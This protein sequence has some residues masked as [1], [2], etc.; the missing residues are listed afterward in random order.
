MSINPNYYLFLVETKN[1][2]TKLLT[3]ALALPMMQGIA[4]LY[5]DARI[6]T[7]GK[8]LYTFQ[9][10]LK[11]VPSWN[12]HI[13]E[14]ETMRIIQKTAEKKIM[15][16]DFLKA[17]IKSNIMILTNTPPEKKDNLKIKHDITIKKFI[18]NAYI[19]IARNIFQ[20]PFL[21]DHNCIDIDIKRNQRETI[22]IIKESI[23][24]TI[25]KLLPLN[26]ILQKYIGETFENQTD[27][28]QN[29]IS[30]SEYNNARLLLNKDPLNNNVTYQLVKNNDIFNQ[31]QNGKQQIV[32]PEQKDNQQIQ[33]K[34]TTPPEQ[35]NIQLPHSNII[36]K[37]MQTKTENAIKETEAAKTINQVELNHKNVLPTP[38]DQSE[39]KQQIENK[40]DD[41]IVSSVAYY[42]RSNNVIEEYGNVKDDHKVDP[43]QQGGTKYD[44]ILNDDNSANIKSIFNDI[45]SLDHENLQI[46]GKH[47]KYLQYKT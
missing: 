27:D 11:H 6:N 41:D 37:I 1:Q 44:E 47:G 29:P 46:K 33:I 12:E 32:Q 2:Y 19:E 39:I 21:F 7:P 30:Q 38:I 18:H 25:V 42:K 15:I 34:L 40:D 14:K 28:F 17:V 10:L 20:N 3:T 4:D 26:I 35:K 24:Q 8:E 13:I 43:K 22:K 23:E 16:E 31:T 36:K 45:S 5:E 9:T